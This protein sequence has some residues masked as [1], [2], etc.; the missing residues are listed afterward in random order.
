MKLLIGASGI[1]AIF[2]SQQLFPQQLS[3]VDKRVS[4]TVVRIGQLAAA[5][6]L[7]HPQKFGEQA[8]S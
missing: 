3:S 7:T 5:A 6:G 1:S 4:L 2:Q 8:G